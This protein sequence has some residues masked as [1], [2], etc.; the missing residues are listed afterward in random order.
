MK[1]PRAT[2]FRTAAALATLALGAAAVPAV[3]QT[4]RAAAPATAEAAPAEAQW[5]D[6]ATV[7]WR[8]EHTAETVEELSYADGGTLRLTP[9]P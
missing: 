2:L 8:A 4:A 7:V 1:P 6:R 9:A 5:I 3:S